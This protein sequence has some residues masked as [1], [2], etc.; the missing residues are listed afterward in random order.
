MIPPGEAHHRHIAYDAANKHVFVAN[1]AMNRVEVFST[2]DQTRIAQI[3]VPGAGSAD[4]SADGATVWVGTITE[5]TVAIDTATLKVRARYAIQQPLSP[6]PNTVFDRPEELVP[7]SS[8]KIMMRLRQ[9]AA[10]QSLLAIWDPLA[11]TLAS[12]SVGPALFQNGLGAMVRTG[13]P[14]ENY[15]RRK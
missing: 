10:A 4:L 1:R 9:S 12:L 15:R 7:M 13:R 3:S 6:I 5:Q 11:N 8:G 14:H 2:P